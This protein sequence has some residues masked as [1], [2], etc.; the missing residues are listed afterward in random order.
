MVLTSPG[1]A[2]LAA[3]RDLPRHV[4]A[5]VRI[6]RASAR[7]RRG[8]WRGWRVGPAACTGWSSGGGAGSWA[9]MRNP[10]RRRAG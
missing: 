4:G 8:G 9:V 5:A 1:L 7:S 10:R 6:S 2:D 3:G